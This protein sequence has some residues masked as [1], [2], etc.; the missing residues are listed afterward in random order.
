MLPSQP[1]LSLMHG[2]HC[3]Q[4]VVAAD[5][6]IGSREV[7]RAAGLEH[8]RVN[9]LLKTLAH[10]GML[11]LTPDRKYAP[12]PGIHLLSAQSLRGSGLLAAALPVLRSLQAPG[13]LVAFG[14]LWEDKVCYLVHAP[15]GTDPADALGAHSPYDAGESIIGL[16]VLAF[17]PPESLPRRLDTPEL[18]RTYRRIRETGYAFLRKPDGDL[19]IAAPV[20]AA[21]PLAAVSLVVSQGALESEGTLSPVILDAARRITGEITRRRPAE[22]SD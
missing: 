13:R 9:R 22:T 3:L 17:L 4:I 2:F 5:R 21:S 20:D 6:P 16:A 15:H 7:A 18:R 11:R 19:S 1:N 12:G 8:T 10:M 14:V